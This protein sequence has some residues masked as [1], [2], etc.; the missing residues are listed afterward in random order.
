MISGKVF[1]T[2]SKTPARCRTRVFNFVSLEFYSVF[3]LVKVCVA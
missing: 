1:S 2:Q 3:F